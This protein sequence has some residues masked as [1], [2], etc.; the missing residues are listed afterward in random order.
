MVP[1]GCREL[2]GDGYSDP[3]GAEMASGGARREID[4]E[5][6]RAVRSVPGLVALFRW[7][8][9][10]CDTSESST[11]VPSGSP[12]RG[13]PQKATCEKALD[14][15]C[16]R[17]ALRSLA[18]GPGHVCCLGSGQSAGEFCLSRQCH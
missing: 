16:G 6:A 15:S 7:V 12:G 14:P 4:R 8:T 11:A 13:F 18:P 10:K 17:C 3:E 5:G 2:Q 1:G 9:S